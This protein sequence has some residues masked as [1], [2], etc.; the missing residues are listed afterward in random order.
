MLSQV[1]DFNFNWHNMYIYA[2]DVAPLLPKGTMLHFLAWYDNTPSNKSNPDPDQWVGWGDRTVDEMGHA[3]INIT[4]YKDDEFKAE[5]AKREAQRR[6][7]ATSTDQRLTQS[8]LGAVLEVGRMDSSH[9]TRS[10][11]SP[12]AAAAIVGWRTVSAGRSGAGPLAAVATDSRAR[13]RAS[14]APSKAG[15]TDKDGSHQPARRLLQPEHEAGVRHPGRSEQPHRAGRARSGA[16]DAF[17]PGPSVRR[18]SRSRCRRT[19][20]T[21][22]LTWTLDRATARPTSIPLHTEAG[23][24]RRAVRGRRLEE[25]AAG[26]EVPAGRRGVDRPA[27]RHGGDV[28]RDAR[29]AAP[30]DGVGDRRGREAER[31]RGPARRGRGAAGAAILAPPPLSLTWSMYRGPGAVKFDEAADRSKR[32]RRQGD[33][34]RDVRRAG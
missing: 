24:R 7:A 17:R 5:L 18:S 10:I 9:G 1:T 8:V 33:H 2:D 32:A 21:K 15:T 12:R 23:L 14:P 31:R 22:K 4:Y 28:H 34:D 3:W 6:R 19:S 11:G 27:R 20:A 13:V 29:R 16:A 25:H 30:A 26:A